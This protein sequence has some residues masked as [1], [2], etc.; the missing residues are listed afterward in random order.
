ML[1][2]IPRPAVCVV[3]FI[4]AVFLLSACGNGE[5]SEDSSSSAHDSGD[6][7]VVEAEAVE[8]SGDEDGENIPPAIPWR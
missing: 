4:Y 3:V 7:T 5:S 1:Y 8:G 6:S 2:R